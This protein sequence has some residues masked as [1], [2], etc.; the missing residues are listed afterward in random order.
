M[1][2][3]LYCSLLL[4][5]SAGCAE[6]SE[7]EPA[8]QSVRPARIFVVQDVRSTNSYEFV[9]QV[10]AAQSIDLS[11]EVSGPLAQ[12]PVRE[13][14]TVR[15]GEVVAALDT[16]DFELAVR[17]AQVQ[18]DLAQHD[19]ERKERVLAQRGIARS[20]VDD[21]RSLFELQRVRLEQARESLTDS[22]LVAPFDAYVARRYVDKHV[23]MR[24][25]DHV[26]RLHDLHQLLVVASVPES[27]LATATTEQVVSTVAQFDFIPTESFDLTYHEN[28]GEADT[29][30]QTYEVSWSMARPERWNILPGM[31]ATIRVE[32]RDPG[33]PVASLVPPSALV[34]GADDSL[35]VW[36]YDAETQ[37]IARRDVITG[38][39]TAKG[40]PVLDGLS[41]GDLIVAT[42]A[43]QLQPGMRVRPL[44]KVPSK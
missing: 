23:N 33:D 19:L 39:P 29:V 10:E 15:R 30:A 11:F 38:P 26:L 36:I 7:P 17:E 18:L 31:T 35:F 27:L 3:L 14:Q 2:Y 13:G 41:G 28:R 8:E 43:S 34:G 40:V 44:G 42:G 9:G 4:T 37:L 16:K 25:G 22:R 32:L 6:R 20:V 24:E 1:K 5:M 21:A 12:L